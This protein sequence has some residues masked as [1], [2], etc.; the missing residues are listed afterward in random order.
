MPRRKQ[1]Q[2]RDKTR[3]D[4][5]ISIPV[6]IEFKKKVEREAKKHKKTVAA[7]VRGVLEERIP[8]GTDKN[9][10]KKKAIFIK[11]SNIPLLPE[12]YAKAERDRIMNAQTLLGI[13]HR[14]GK[15][16]DDEYERQMNILSGEM[17]QWLKKTSK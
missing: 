12:E 11:E 1:E 7:Y 2:D 15:I 13:E 10:L 6:T 17:R 4:A 14:E 16:T 3:Y 8:D 5:D 9:E